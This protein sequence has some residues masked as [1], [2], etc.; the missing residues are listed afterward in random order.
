MYIKY[1]K[2]KPVLG[3]KDLAIN[4]RT[5]K[6]MEFDGKIIGI[7]LKDVLNMVTEE[8]LSN[9]EKEIETYVVSK[10]K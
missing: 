3:V 8:K 7:I 5:L 10:Y 9:E 2:S 6:Q 1:L 4:G